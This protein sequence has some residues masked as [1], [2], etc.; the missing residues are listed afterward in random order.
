MFQAFAAHKI[1]PSMVAVDVNLATRD[2]PRGR[3]IFPENEDES[4]RR[5]HISMYWKLSTYTPGRENDCSALTYLR[6]FDED[7]GYLPNIRIYQYPERV[8]EEMQPE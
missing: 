3:S 7:K 1:R 2:L 4:Y 5:T 6:T 8:Q